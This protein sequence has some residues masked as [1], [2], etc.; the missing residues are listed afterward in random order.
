ML[1]HGIKSNHSISSH[2][3]HYSTLRP[4]KHQRERESFLP[5]LFS[6]PKPHPL[7][8]LSSDIIISYSGWVSWEEGKV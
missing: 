7:L 5:F 3:L 4:L 1:I 2:Y 6:T 8:S